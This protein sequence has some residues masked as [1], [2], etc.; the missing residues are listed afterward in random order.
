MSNRCLH[1]GDVILGNLG[2]MLT[3]QQEQNAKKCELCAF[4]I[5]VT[6]T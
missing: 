5:F 1:S 2:K 4:D 6:N 3:T